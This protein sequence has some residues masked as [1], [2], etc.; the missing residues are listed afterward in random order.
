MI[1]FTIILRESKMDIIGHYT[2]LDT[3]L[4]Y[5]IKTTQLLTCSLLGFGVLYLL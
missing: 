5:E 3:L 1:F 2:D 4:R